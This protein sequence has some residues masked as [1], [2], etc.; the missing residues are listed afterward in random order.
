M[1]R[2]VVDRTEEFSGSGPYQR[3][4]QGVY[5]LLVHNSTE[6]EVYDRNGA[7]KLLVRPGGWMVKAGKFEGGLGP[8]MCLNYVRFHLRDRE[9]EVRD[10]VF[11]SMLKMLLVHFMSGDSPKTV[12]SV[13]T[14]L[15]RRLR[16][17]LNSER[18]SEGDQA[19]HSES[20]RLVRLPPDDFETK[21][22]KLIVETIEAR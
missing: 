3:R 2:D 8:R 20:R 10:S 6:H 19:G 13:E 18:L 14:K 16:E 22:K 9:T 17:L 4:E 5:L 11:P 15:K 21:L 12:R 1:L 7:G